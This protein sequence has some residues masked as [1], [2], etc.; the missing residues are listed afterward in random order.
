MSKND[1]RNNNPLYFIRL[2]LVLQKP[3]LYTGGICL[4]PEAV[5][6]SPRS[7]HLLRVKAVL[8]L[9]R[10]TNP[11]KRAALYSSV[12]TGDQNP[13]AEFERNLIITIIERVR[14]GLRRARLEGIAL[15]HYL[16][17]RKRWNRCQRNRSSDIVTAQSERI[18][19]KNCGQC[20]PSAIGILIFLG[21]F[22]S[23]TFQIRLS[24]ILQLGPCTPG[25]LVV[26]YRNAGIDVNHTSSLDQFWFS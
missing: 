13:E 6:T 24:L 7:P 14:A 20:D 2:E 3:A 21:F 1:A 22:F 12:F 5:A 23:Q 26:N 19:H 15:A 16:F 4:S 18:A 8:H 10:E 25:R 9:R 17:G 11:I